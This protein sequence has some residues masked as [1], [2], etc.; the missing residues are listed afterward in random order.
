MEG[1][2]VLKHTAALSVY[3]EWED[4]RGRRGGDLDRERPRGERLRLLRRLLPRL[5][6]E[7]TLTHASAGLRCRLC[8][9]ACVSCTGHEQMRG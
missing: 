2:R 1:G 5:L 9:T 6:V 4:R 8:T 3:R 7:D